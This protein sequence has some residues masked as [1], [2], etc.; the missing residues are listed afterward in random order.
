MYIGKLWLYTEETNSCI[1]ST[2]LCLLVSPDFA[3]STE[4][5]VWHQQSLAVNCQYC[6]GVRARLHSRNLDP[7]IA[8]RRAAVCKCAPHHC[9]RIV[10]GGEYVGNP[11]KW[12]LKTIHASDMNCP[13]QNYF[14]Q[15]IIS[16]ISLSANFLLWRMSK[17]AI[18]GGAEG[19]DLWY[20][21][22]L[23]WLP[24]VGVRKSGMSKC[25]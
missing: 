23:V 25:V 18:D 22:A 10:C 6:A 9:C 17:Q 20:R 21:D 11:I 3:D 24:P 12:L 2:S 16:V 4:S 5:I 1:S 7:L 13:D 8:T 14:Y 15:H 19:E